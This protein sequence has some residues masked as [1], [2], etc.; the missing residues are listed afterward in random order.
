MRRYTVV[1]SQVCTSEPLLETA[2]R[3]LTIKLYQAGYSVY[4]SPSNGPWNQ[5][6]HSLSDRLDPLTVTGE[7]IFSLQRCMPDVRMYVCLNC[8]IAW[9]RDVMNR[10]LIC[11]NCLGTLSRMTNEEWQEATHDTTRRG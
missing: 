10:P 5:H 2:A 3:Y 1:A 7:P 8:R 11:P 6:V 9:D 4:V